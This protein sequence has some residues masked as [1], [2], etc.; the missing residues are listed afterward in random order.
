M[1]EISAAKKGQIISAICEG[2]SI[3]STARQCELS[4]NTVSRLVNLV[5][6]AAERYMDAAF[7]DL[8]IKR[9]EADEIWA[10]CSAKDKNV[11]ENHEDDRDYGSIWTWTAI[12]ADTKLISSWYVGNRTTD[13]CF[14]FLFDLRSR[15]VP[16]NRFQLTTDGFRSYRTAVDALWGPDEIDY[17]MVIKDY[18]S[19]TGPGEWRY[20]PPT[21][22]S[23]EKKVVHGDP[24]AALISTSYVERQNLTMRMNM[25]RMTRLTNG[26]SKKAENHALATALHFAYY[27]LARPH[28]TLTKKAGTK[29]TPAM[30][31]GVTDRPWTV[32]DLVG[33][34]DR[35]EAL[36]A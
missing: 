17:A 9:V 18:D 13:D 4:A 21:C 10:F 28:Q 19:A 36:A 6:V 30:A 27:N 5:A 34:V 25:R 29:T 22:K 1:N 26:F 33:L 31:A 15:M 8:D 24:D 32:H 3:R 23:I 20:S 2:A 12:D 7:R 14:Q 35:Y 11:P 16:G